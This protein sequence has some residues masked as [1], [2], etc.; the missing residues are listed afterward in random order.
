MN[1]PTDDEIGALLRQTYHSHEYLADNPSGTSERP[2]TLRDDQGRRTRRPLILAAA[3]VVLLVGAVGLAASVPWSTPNSVPPV[4]TDSSPGVV[5]TRVPSVFGYDGDAARTMLE[6]S[7]LRVTEQVATSCEVQGRALGTEPDTDEPIRPG[8]QITLLVAQTSPEARCQ[9][10]D[11]ARR[12][13]WEFLDF[14]NGRGPAPDFADT[15]ELYVD[16]QGPIV[17]SGD[18][19]QSPPAWSA[20]FPSIQ[21]DTEKVFRPQVDPGS[22]DRT[23][24]LGAAQHTA[25]PTMGC[26]YATPSALIGRPVVSATFTL[27]TQSF[28]VGCDVQVDIFRTDGEIDA[29]VASTMDAETRMTVASDVVGLTKS[30]AGQDLRQSGFEVRSGQ[31]NGETCD[32]DDLIIAQDPTPTEAVVS[33]ATIVLTC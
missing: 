23:L 33:G 6:S 18:E 21:A 32:R 19:R 2:V 9:R 31:A 28:Y 14:A 29:I 4:A 27:R 25:T 3:S 20:L 8:Q 10:N 17:L 16:G 1:K 13:A 15:V 22:S 24:S 30:K 26:V 5:V 12:Q 11:E 7:G